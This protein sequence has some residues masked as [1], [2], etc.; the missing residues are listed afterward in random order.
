MS[1]DIVARHFAPEE[2]ID[3]VFDQLPPASTKVLN[4]FGGQ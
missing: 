1:V 3:G 2:S 4:T